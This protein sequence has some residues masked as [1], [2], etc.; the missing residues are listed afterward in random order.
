MALRIFGRSTRRCVTWFVLSGAHRETI[1][2]CG[3][4]RKSWWA[5]I[6]IL[7]GPEIAC[8]VYVRSNAECTSTA[9][10]ENARRGS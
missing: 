7:L 10:S 8:F 2:R 5:V 6:D 3:W 9:E 4:S 1:G